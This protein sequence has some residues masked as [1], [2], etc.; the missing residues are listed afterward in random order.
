MASR[1]NIGK[2][3][4]MRLVFIRHGDPDYVHDSLTE[5]GKKEAE[6]LANLLEDKEL[7]D[8]YVSPLGR[9]RETASYTIERIRKNGRLKKEPVTFDWLE[10]FP[11]RV[12]LER[13]EEARKAFATDLFDDS[14]SSKYKLHRMWDFLPSYY[15]EH[16]ELFD[17]A[18]W[19]KA[20]IVKDSSAEE[21]YDHVIR[22]FD[23]LLASYGYERRGLLYHCDEGNTKTLTFFCHFGIT[24]VL[25]S[26]LMNVSPFSL[27]QMT[28]SAP[29]S[30]TEAVSEERQKGTAIFRMLRFGDTTHLT[31]GNE[32]PSFSAR[33]CERFEHMDERH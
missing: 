8:I 9:A 1:F 23:S 13:S 21:I 31:V 22:E 16:P 26:H 2:E 30:V 19:R 18:D 7:G 20:Q 33:F 24:C 32:N 4:D 3:C 11:A 17:S 6:L 15:G 10:E 27:L 28:A 14:G 12:D 25:L 29:T 5:K